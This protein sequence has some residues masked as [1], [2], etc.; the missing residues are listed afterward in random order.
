MKTFLQRTISCLIIFVCLLA[1][2]AVKQVVNAE[3]ELIFKIQNNSTCYNNGYASS[4]TT[5]NKS[6]ASS[7]LTMNYTY[8]GVN[9]QSSSGSAYTYKMYVK[10]NGF[11]Y[12][13][14][15][16][17][18]YY[19][20]SVE[21]TFSSTTGTSGKII[22]TFSDSIL[23]S[24]NTSGTATPTK[25]GTYKM[26]NSDATK[27]YWNF[28][29]TGANVQVTDIVVKYKQIPSED[30]TNTEK[31]MNLD[32]LASLNLGW[33]SE[34][35]VS[36]SVENWKLV[37]DASEL[38]EGDQIIIAA[39]DYNYA[40]STTQ[41]SN[42][43]GQTAITK[44]DQNVE[45]ENNVQV[46]T[47]KTGKTSGTFGFYTGSGYLYAASSSSNYLRTETSLSS[48]SSWKITVTSAGVA[49]IIAQGTNTRKTMQYNQSSSLFACYSSASQK[50]LSIYKKYVEEGLETVHSIKE[51]SVALRFGTL[52]PAEIYED[53]LSQGYKFGVNFVSGTKNKDFI[54]AN[55]EKVTVEDKEYYQYAVVIN[56][57]PVSAYKE[58][59]TAT[60]FAELNGEQVKM[61]SKTHSVV[62]ILTAYVE[63]AE[64]SE[65][66]YGSLDK[67]LM[68]GLLTSANK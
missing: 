42:N 29:T 1:C 31:F 40:L 59:F 7:G 25:S 3:D 2:F 32:T 4:G 15:I 61:N 8:Y 56:N 47:L 24:R 37:T 54:C 41:N 28:S 18:G 68:A 55:V 64:S 65:E 44:I 39:K 27:L 52:V 49:T 19:V 38:A 35:V 5:A 57:I 33:T 23:S 45:F 13:T 62:S 66:Y 63:M 60:C 22:T 46:L 6:V 36:S 16:V 11:I 43:R 67:D 30:L 50:A 53:L 12:S 9:T 21:V 34:E 26:E 14:S 10:N 20:S 58:E 51:G 48:N 17:E